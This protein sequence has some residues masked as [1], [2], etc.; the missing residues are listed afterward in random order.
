MKNNDIN[1][2]IMKQITIAMSLLAMILSACS[3]EAGEAPETGKTPL[4]MG[5]ITIRHCEERSNPDLTRM[6][7]FG[8][9]RNDVNTRA[10]AEDFF[11]TGDGLYIH[12]SD[13]T[14]FSGTDWNGTAFGA[15]S[16]PIYFED[17][18]NAAND[19]QTKIL[20]A[21]FGF[22]SEILAEQHIETG[23]HLA[24]YITGTLSVDPATKTLN[25]ATMTRQNTQLIIRITK[26]EGWDSDTDFL[27]HFGDRTYY[28]H[29]NTVGTNVKPYQSA[30]TSG[31]PLTLTCL[32][33]ADQVPAT[34]G[35]DL[36]T[37]TVP[38]SNNAT[39]TLKLTDAI[40]PEEGKSIT[41][42]AT[43]HKQGTFAGITAKLAEWVD[44]TH[45]GE[46]PALNPDDLAAELA[47]REAEKQRFLAWATGT[48]A[49][50]WQT[51]D[52]TLKCD[53]NLGGE[54]FEPIGRTSDFKRTFDGGGYTISGLKINKPED[55]NIGLFSWIN[56]AGT[57]RNLTVA[58]EITGDYD[59]GGIAGSNR[60]TIS[61]CTF[62]GKVTGNGSNTG[63]IAGWNNG[64]IAGCRV[65]QSTITGYGNTGG[66][67]GNNSENATGIIACLADGVTLKGT[68]IGGAL[69]GIAGTNEAPLVACVAAPTSM[70]SAG[71]YTVA[72]GITGSNFS[73][74]TTCYWQTGSG[75]SKAIGEEYNTTPQEPNGTPFAP[76]AFNTLTG[77]VE[78]LNAAIDEWN[79]ANGGACPFKWETT[80]QGVGAGLVSAQ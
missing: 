46:L 29:T 9:P 20:T 43:Y 56:A 75:Y 80:P 28:I 1:N 8:A 48:G 62:Q 31:S 2:M 23:L 61:G 33:P 79:A 7:C 58:G 40:A 3:Q 12:S 34:A 26:G 76:G 73:T 5:S 38:G 4:N 44:V 15:L 21:E 14:I 72:G 16:T 78:A 24:E 63:G 37:L 59:T 74:L 77:A 57:V 25:C 60:G 69:G 17:V 70:T 39:R 65:V 45:N 71:I 27:S 52:F 54:D 50:S 30:Y 6:D 49:G 47:R 11:R 53:I 68:D 22:G 66:I 41:I 10:T 35:A 64:L 19:E 51:T 42:T 32:L 55:D 18:Y 36:L 13:G 67:A